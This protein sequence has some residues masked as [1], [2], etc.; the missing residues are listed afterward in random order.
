MQLKNG[1]NTGNG[2]YAQKGT[3]L[4]LMVA[5]RP[6]IIFLPDGNTSPSSYGYQF[7]QLLS[8]Q[9]LNSK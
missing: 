8:L 7:K 3:T 2:T 9:I 4:K 1:R 6:K 5:D